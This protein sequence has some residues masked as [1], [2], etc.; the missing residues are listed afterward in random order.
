MVMTKTDTANAP[1]FVQ[2]VWSKITADEREKQLFYADKLD[3]RYE[4]EFA[5]VPTDTV[6]VQGVSAPNSGASRPLTNPG[7][8]VV[9]DIGAFAT[10]LDIVVNTHIYSAFDL[11]VELAMF[12]NISLA[13]KMAGKAAYVVKLKVDTDCATLIDDGVT[14]SGAVG[15]AG[16]ALTDADVIKG[17]RTLNDAL[18]PVDGRYFVYT[19]LQQ[20]EFMQV[21]RYI[22]MGYGS[23][24]GVLKGE[25]FNQGFDARIYGM[26]WS[27]ST[28]AIGQVS[29]IWNKEFAAIII[30]DEM[31]TAEAYD[32]DTDSMKHA[33]HQLYG[34]KTMR[35]D[36]LVWMKGV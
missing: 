12:S 36:H 2:E 21:E 19:S 27:M 10:Q 26:D 23:S 5:G 30:K 17:V 33:V 15:T 14:G 4:A 31:R 29:G 24:T 11:E 22:H 8:P 1:A 32:I 34:V 35:A 20:A 9:Y 3:R 7:D 13:E 16:Q 6:H 25:N 18:A 28:N